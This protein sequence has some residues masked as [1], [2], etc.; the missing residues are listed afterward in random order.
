MKP[1]ELDPQMLRHTRAFAKR[2]RLTRRETDMLVAMVS[3]GL[4]TKDLAKALGIQYNT[5]CNHLKGLFERTETYSKADVLAKLYKSTF[6]PHVHS[7]SEDGPR[8]ALRWGSCSTEVC[9]C[10]AWRTPDTMNKEWRTDTD[11]QQAAREAQASV[12][13][14]L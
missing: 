13:E 7:K 12:D 10:G 6:A 14:D 5:A 11:V 3:G 9:E 1:S 2:H 4:A 8:I